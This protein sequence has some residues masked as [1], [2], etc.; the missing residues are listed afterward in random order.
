MAD[1]PNASSPESGS[2]GGL[3]PPTGGVLVAYALFAAGAVA[4]L[5]SSGGIVVAAPLMSVFGI[6]GIIVCYV[7]Q[8]EVRGTWVATHFR[9]LVRTFWYSLLWGIVGGIIFV[10]LF[11]VFLLGPV[12]AFGLWGVTSVWVLYRVIRGYLL[13]NDGK[14]VPGM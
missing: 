13:F 9:W 4:A 14:P 6:I 1:F 3:A 5:V 7:K 8:D 12:L 10:L 11:V 2:P